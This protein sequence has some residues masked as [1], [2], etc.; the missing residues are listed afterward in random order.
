VSAE[1]NARWHLDKKISLTHMFATVSA[2]GTLV[3]FGSN[4]TT[5]VALIEQAVG[6]FVV[7]QRTVDTRQDVERSELRRQMREDY[8]RIDEKL[9]RIL[10]ER[11]QK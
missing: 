11:V 2:I 7:E 4:L 1:D 6:T 3:I 5:R 10:H 8:G 9:D